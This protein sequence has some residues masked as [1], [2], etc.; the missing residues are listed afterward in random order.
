VPLVAIVVCT[1]L[2]G[3]WAEGHAQGVEPS[4]SVTQRYRTA[5]VT[6]RDSVSRVR[7]DIARFRRDLQTAGARTVENRSRRLQSSCQALGATLV[8]TEPGVRV[9][10]RPGPRADELRA[11]E[12][13]LVQQMRSVRRVLQDLCEQGLAPT[14]PGQWA[15]SLK[16][17]GP[18]RTSR[19]EQS[20]LGLHG[21][22]ARFAGAAGIKIEPR[23]PSD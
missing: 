7:S 12:R 4:D 23:L 1:T 18:S 19:L 10:P 6:L 11:A 3:S 5:L 20:L 17:W 13:D 9:N 21:A 15:D 16:A 14:G 2:V 8:E 22:S